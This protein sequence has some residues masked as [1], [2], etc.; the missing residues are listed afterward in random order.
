M[1]PKK[2]STKKH[3]AFFFSSVYFTTYAIVMNSVIYIFNFFSCHSGQNCINKI[4]GKIL[5]IIFF[6]CHSSE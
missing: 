4:V 1:T 2:N 3:R 5:Y 6:V